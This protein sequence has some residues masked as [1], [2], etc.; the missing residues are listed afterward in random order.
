MERSAW[1]GRAHHATN[2]MATEQTLIMYETLHKWEVYS[3]SI[4]TEL[5]QATDEGKDIGAWAD[6]AKAIE[7]LPL[8]DLREAAADIFL[9]AVMDAPIRADFPYVEPDDLDGIR[10]QRPENRLSF[11]KPAADDVLKD[12]IRGA[13]LGRICGCLLGKPVEGFRTPDLHGMLKLSGNFPLT[14]YITSADYLA[15][16]PDPQKVIGMAMANKKWIDKLDGCAPVDD[17]TNY[18]VMAAK[19][20]IDKYG[21][22]FTPDNVAEAWVASQPKNAYCTA[23][24]RA[25]KNFING[26]MPPMSALY[27]NP[28]REFIGAQIRADYFGYINPGNPDLAA[29]MAWRDA[30]ISH[31]KNGIYGEMYVAAM[32]A[33]AAVTDDIKTIIQAG[34]D[35]IP[36]KSRLDASIAEVLAW[37]DA[38]VTQEECF[39]RIHARYDEFDM[40]NWVHTISNAMIVTASLLYGAGDYSKSICMSVQV[41]FDTDCNGATVGSI[42]GMMLGTAG[43]GEEWTGPIHGM[44]DTAIFGVNKISVDELVDLTMKHL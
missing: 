15:Y 18:T 10:A 40:Y 5:R 33:A 14:R 20:V 9:K 39:G 35:Q 25:F 21:R 22:D 36:A 44:V 32:I 24:R 2:K 19:C 30:C 7:E 37:F 6:F 42:L 1:K 4:L 27:K 13:W 17:D 3:R 16:N 41:G 28:D 29:D 11:A 43:V 8:G 23:E 26:I 31:V 34:R 38:G 12:K